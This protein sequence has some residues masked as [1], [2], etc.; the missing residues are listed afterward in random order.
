MME[1]VVEPILCSVTQETLLL[2]PHR[3]LDA[4]G[5]KE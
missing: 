4:P 3:R 5:D 2:P 1:V